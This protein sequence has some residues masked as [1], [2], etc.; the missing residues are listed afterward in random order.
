MKLF[1]YYEKDGSVRA[2]IL[3]PDGPVGL[4]PGLKMED[5]LGREGEELLEYAEKGGEPSCVKACPKQAIW[6]EEV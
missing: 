6:V 1:Q 5:L 3:G 2:G 4:A